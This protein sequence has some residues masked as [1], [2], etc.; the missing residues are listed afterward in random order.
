MTN[1][2]EKGKD[3]KGCLYEKD[4]IKE[5]ERISRNPNRGFQLSR[6]VLTDSTT[7]D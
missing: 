7:R 6:P 1:G 3:V 2:C 5:A 4:S